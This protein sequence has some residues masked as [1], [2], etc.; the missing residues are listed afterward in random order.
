[1]REFNMSAQK[2]RAKTAEGLVKYPNL[3]TVDRVRVDLSTH[4]EE[5]INRNQINRQP[6]TGKY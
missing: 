5:R 2:L 1:M 6:P 4:H 3:D